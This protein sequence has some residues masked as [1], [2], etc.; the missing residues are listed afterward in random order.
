[1]IKSMTSHALLGSALERGQ[2]G[3]HYFVDQKEVAS[4]NGARVDHLPLDVVVVVDTQVGWVDHFTAGTVHAD[5]TVGVAG[6][7]K[8]FNQNFLRIKTWKVIK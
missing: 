7:T 1:M 4:D 2:T 6:F 8:K 3:P 5:W